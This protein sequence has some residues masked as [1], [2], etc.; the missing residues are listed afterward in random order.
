MRP[1]TY[2]ALFGSVIAGS[3]VPNEMQQRRCE[4]LASSRNI[5]K[6][7][8]S[9]NVNGTVQ[10][11]AKPQCCMGFFKLVDGHFRPDLLGCSLVETPCPE[12][13][14][15]ASTLLNNYTKCLCSSDFCNINITWSPGTE[16]PQQSNPQDSSQVFIGHKLRPH[17]SHSDER[18]ASSTEGLTSHCS[19]SSSA[20]SDIDM[21]N[22]KLEKFVACGRFGLV[23]QGSYQGNVVALKHFRFKNHHE[24]TRERA[25]YAVPLMVHAG[26]VHFLGA[27]ITVSGEPMLVMEFALHGSLNSYL[28]K[29]M[30]TWTDAVRLSKSLV[31]GLV[32]LHSDLNSNGM[33]KPPL[34]HRDLSSN[35]VLVRADGT[36]ALCDFGCA[37]I[38]CSCGGPD[39]WQHQSSTSREHAPLGT[40]CYMPPEILDRSVDLNSA[41]CLLQ[42][43]VYALGLLLWEMWMRCMDLFP[44]LPVPEHHLPYETEL[45]A[46]P[47]LGQLLVFVFEKRGRPAIPSTWA[48][49]SQTKKN[50]LQE[51][52]EECWDH[53]PEARLNAHCAANRI[54]SLCTE[55]SL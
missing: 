23:W 31:E 27:G 24:F 11:C 5:D 37:T 53:D 16:Q 12:T 14:C 20:I 15:S 21:A 1:L 55:Y 54:A 32:Y 19:C 17:L 2:T 36:C 10:Y 7:L 25:V 39:Q 52:L 45:G 8:Q 40:L 22:M 28:S 48:T 41:L 38:L 51:L 35:N 43:D 9:G 30:I 46:K 47:T 29:T 4:F 3:P 18:A 13:T 50:T 34:A 6:A 26:I 49:V 42:G 44:E 33:H